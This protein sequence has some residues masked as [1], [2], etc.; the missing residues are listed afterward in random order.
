MIRF[1]GQSPTAGVGDLALSSRLSAEVYEAVTQALSVTS[2]GLED[3][4]SSVTLAQAMGWSSVPADRLRDV[5]DPVEL[6]EFL[7]GDAGDGVYERSLAELDGRPARPGVGS[8]L[9]LRL[10][11]T[12]PTILARQDGDPDAEGDVIAIVELLGPAG[13]AC[14]EVW[15][16][17][18]P[19]R[20]VAAGS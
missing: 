12:F 14:H 15:L 16:P 6:A 10:K 13:G 17:L 1:D 7:A 20:L 3:G 9:S 19:A 11:V 5:L 4:G 8:R 2:G 18:G